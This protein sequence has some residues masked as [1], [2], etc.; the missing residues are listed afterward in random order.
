MKTSLLK[1]LYPVIT[2]LVLYAVTANAQIVYTDVNPDTIISCTP[3][4]GLSPCSITDSF[5]LNRDGK[6]DFY[7]FYSYSARKIN[8]CSYHDA[9]S[10]LRR[11]DSNKIACDAGGIFA[12]NDS[13]IISSNLSWNINYLLESFHFKCI[14]HYSSRG[15]WSGGTDKYAAITI[16]KN[17]LLYFGWIRLLVNLSVSP[18]ISSVTLKDYAYNSIPNQ[19]ILAGEKSCT[20]PTVTLSASGSLS[21]CTGDS[22][23][24]T[25]NG[26]G[27][28]YQW[29]KDGV[30]I[31]GA[32][33]K[34][35][36]AKT[37]G[38][39]KCKVTNSCGTVTSTGKKVTV[40]CL[41]SNTALN[42]EQLISKVTRL[43]ITPNPFSN[44]TTIS[45]S[46]PFSQKVSIQIFDAAG[47]SIQ[48][49]ANAE[50][51]GGAHQLIWDAK[52]ENGSAVSAG[53]Y[54]LRMKTGNYSETK[55]LI[56]VR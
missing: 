4:D 2:A 14:N 6:K 10:D 5:D 53:I 54:F 39:Y 56:I 34:K 32:T 51:Q 31:S 16:I 11:L 44:T 38:T 1:K 49:L 47:R 18:S 26:S 55:K 46:L 29:K 52:G 8:G 48:T 12:L 30:N 43:Q 50:M 27:Y 40:T 7:V 36:V 28:L 19:P 13:S 17:G 33:Q 35:Y 25:A 15:H 41:S 20:T 42:N 3:Q 23:T 45:F 24:L 37:A 21:F 9:E 22:V